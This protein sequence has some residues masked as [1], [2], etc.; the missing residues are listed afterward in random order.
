MIWASGAIMPPA[1]LAIPLADRIFEHGLGLF[2]TFRTW[3]GRAPLLRRHLDRLRRSALALDIDLAGVM[4]PDPG[5]VDHLARAIGHPDAL[6]RLTVSAGR[7][8]QIP[9]TCWMAAAPLPPASPRSGWRVVAAPWPVAVADRL[10]RHK[11]LNYWAKRMAFE[12]AQAL[13]A[14][15][16]VVGSADGRS[17]EGSRTS[18]FLIRGETLLTPPT[19]GPIVPGIMRALVLE[20]AGGAGFSAAEA[21][22]TDA[23]VDVADEVFLANSVRGLVPVRQWDGRGYRP[24]S[25]A[26]DATARLQ[27]AVTD[28]LSPPRMP[29]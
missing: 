18:L 24:T 28:F 29:P 9:P 26:F 20:R 22:I 21:D 8:D 11:T 15:E 10:A 19:S 12:H 16:A 7:P 14:D 23:Q 4:L 3:D 27:R 13:G 5:A 6:L 2:E 25:F 1:G 17:W